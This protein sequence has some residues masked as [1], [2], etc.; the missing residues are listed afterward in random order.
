M[1]MYWQVSYDLDNRVYYEQPHSTGESS[2]H[3]TTTQ[4]AHIQGSK[5]VTHLAHEYEMQSTTESQHEYEMENGARPG[6]MYKYGNIKHSTTAGENYASLYTHKI[7]EVWYS[8]YSG[9]QDVVS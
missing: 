6:H 2:N 4:Q 1:Y 7:H 3:P 5:T 9:M 8:I